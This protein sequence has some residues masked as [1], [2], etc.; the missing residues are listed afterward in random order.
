MSSTRKA[1]RAFINLV[2]R[3]EAVEAAAISVAHRIG[4]LI[5]PRKTGPSSSP[6]PIDAVYL[7]VDDTDA[8]WLRKK[9]EFDHS[10]VD[11][12]SASRFRE[13]GELQA[14]LRLLARNAPWLRRAFIVTDAQTPRLD[15]VSSY[16]FEIVIV[17][18]TDLLPKKFLPT[19]SSRALTAN[20]HRITDLSEAFIYM[21]DD[22]F[23]AAPSSW[24][25]FFELTT[26]GRPIAKLRNTQTGMPPR[27]SLP[28][29]EIVFESRYHTNQIA[30]SKGWVV[31]PGPPEHGGHAMLKSVVA[32]LWNEVPTEME[33]ASSERFRK[34]NTVLTEWLHDSY[35]FAKGLALDASG[36][37]TYKYVAI[38]STDAAGALVDVML[39][40][41]RILVLCLNDVANLPKE[42]ILSSARVQRRMSRVLKRL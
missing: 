21:N 18:H 42:E 22:T 26:D 29:G 23:I 9:S 1:I 8:T 36:K 15:S 38:N 31:T 20:L 7:W 32:A 17:D 41:D 27:E 5:A 10:S 37:T 33:L 4:Q 11:A 40:R 34:P 13:F 28:A 35:A 3:S 2:T 12:D 6:I 39:R 14:S 16:P 24:S 25:D 30:E 19:F